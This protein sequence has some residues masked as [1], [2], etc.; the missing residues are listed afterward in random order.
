MSARRLPSQS[1]VGMFLLLCM[2]RW[3]VSGAIP[4]DENW[5][6]T[7]GVPGADSTV[8]AIGVIGPR[9]YLG[10]SFQSIGGTA[11]SNIAMWNGTRWSSLDS[12]V[13]G[14]VLD[15]LPFGSSVFVAGAFS[16]AGGLSSRGLARW[17]G[18]TWSTPGSVDGWIHTL[19]SDGTNLFIG[20]QFTAINGLRAL[21]IAQWNGINW[22]AIGSITNHAPGCSH[23][24]DDG[25]VFSLATRGQ[26][27]F[28]GGRFVYAGTVFATN[29]A[30]WDG[31]NWSS[32][33]GGVNGP[34]RAITHNRNGLF[35]G[36]DFSRVGAVTA[37]KVAKWDGTNWFSLDGG[38]GD[39]Y[40]FS[41]L[42]VVSN[43]EDIYLGGGFSKIGGALASGVAKWN[44]QAWEALGSGVSGAGA[45]ATTGSE[46]FVAGDFH[47]SGGKP[48]TNI[49]LW[50]IPHPLKVERS[51]DQ[52]RLSWPGT[53]T[54]F[55][56]EACSILDSS[57]WASV[58]QA[59]VA[60]GSELTVTN[61]V[62]GPTRFYRLRRR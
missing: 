2:A 19:A 62:C 50:H 58:P 4:G 35:I 1:V 40:P 36:G 61:E 7:F 38:V 39:A 30:K 28:V 23:C 48:A 45:L 27:L 21:R 29:L 25:A 37:K 54:N 17:D 14:T 18:A 11:A 53:G 47:F 57:N 55:A 8:E 3:M 46:L 22:H 26:E 10:G 43:G 15:L 52:L 33:G 20:G 59:P 9:L 34:V 6:N 41:V 60:A 32:V 24:S 49:A 16:T 51:G 31:T 12:G 42:A 56:L 44:G 13:D 5:D